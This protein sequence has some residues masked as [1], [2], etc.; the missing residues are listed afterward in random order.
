M[1]DN[2]NDSSNNQ[3]PIKPEPYKPQPIRMTLIEK[4]RTGNRFDN[5]KGK[6]GTKTTTTNKKK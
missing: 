2:K 1:T 3:P 6:S 4:G 5:S